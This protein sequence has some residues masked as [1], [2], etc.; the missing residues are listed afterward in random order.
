MERENK[1]GRLQI[2]FEKQF[3]KA[4]LEKAQNISD[5]LRGLEIEDFTV[6]QSEALKN[7]LAFYMLQ[8][9]AELEN[10]VSSPVIE[11]ARSMPFFNIIVHFA[12]TLI[13]AKNVVSIK[14]KERYSLQYAQGYDRS[15]PKMPLLNLA[16]YLSSLYLLCEKENRDLA[17][18][19]HRNSLHIQKLLGNN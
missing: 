8:K 1:P 5:I 10:A 11:T 13:E 19:M 14:L 2:Y 6:E 12:D 3:E 18:E 4:Y 16:N 7:A 17:A 9:D 15:L